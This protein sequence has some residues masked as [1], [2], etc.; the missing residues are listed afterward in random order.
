MKLWTDLPP[1][2]G[3]ILERHRD[4]KKGRMVNIFFGDDG[5]VQVSVQRGND[6]AYGN[7]IAKP[8]QSILM[9]LV[10]ALGPGAGGS[11]AAHL[12]LK[13]IDRRAQQTVEAADE[14]DDDFSDI[15]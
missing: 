8:G 9:A 10:E 7:A 13:N 14:D 5:T 1:D 6:S 12:D 4:L 3:T 15:I 11:W 2:I